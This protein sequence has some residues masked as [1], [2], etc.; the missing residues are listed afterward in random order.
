MTS[1][2]EKILN[3][4]SLPYK[5]RIEELTKIMHRQREEV[6]IRVVEAED[7]LNASVW[8]KVHRYLFG[9]SYDSSYE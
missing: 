9:D 8:T 1:E 4:Q 3:T 7:I 6:N 2:W 5:E